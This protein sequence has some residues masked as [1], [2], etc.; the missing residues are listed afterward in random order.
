[1]DF[2]DLST[3]DT[4]TMKGMVVA[5]K[6]GITELPEKK[7]IPF[8]EDI[9]ESF[10]NNILDGL[11]EFLM[12]EQINQSNLFIRAF[13]YTYGKGVEFALSHVIGRPME[14]IGFNFDDCMKGKTAID[15]PVHISFRVHKYTSALIEMYEE[16]YE[17]AND[18]TDEL[19]QEGYNLSDNLFK[20]LSG[21][22][23]I[24]KR[25]AQSLDIDSDEGLDFSSNLIDVK[26]DYD[27]Y[28]GKYRAED[29]K[30]ATINW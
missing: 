2:R 14:R 25:V 21:A 28:N 9:T 10:I 1:M 15:L 30:I 23:Y 18:H 4:I 6:Y 22:F 12:Y 19:I 29:F 5:Y 11:G 26:Y 3:Y 17:F 8:S 24:G 13:L 16:M 27:T 7:P 20:I